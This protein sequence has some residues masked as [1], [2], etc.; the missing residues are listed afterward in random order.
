[1][2]RGSAAIAL[3]AVMFAAGCY[4]KMGQQPRYDPLEPSDFFADG[5]SA[6][7]RIAGTVA[8]GELH[9]DPYFETGLVNGQPGD[10]F[11]FPVTEEVIDR[12]ESRYNIYCS[13]CHGRTGDGN[14]MIPSRGYR[15][16]PSFHTEK[17]RTAKAGHFFDVMTNG[18]GSMPPYKTMV[19]AA[20]RWAIAA[21]LRAL[22]LSQG[23]TMADVPAEG[24]AALSG[25]AR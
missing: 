23:A 5:M 4:Q 8:R 10:G 22:Q 20:D 19:P 16:P 24:R 7:P 6:R 21:Y 13:Q 17:L 15:R 2:S 3:A 18:F 11:P 25:G 14:G 12:G 1:M 9:V